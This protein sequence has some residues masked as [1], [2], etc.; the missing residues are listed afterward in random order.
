[1]RIAA[2]FLALFLAATPSFGQ[3]VVPGSAPPAALTG[4]IDFWFTRL[5]GATNQEDAAMAENEIQRLWLQSGSVTVD[6]VMR[7][8]LEATQAGVYG[9]ALDLLDGVIALQPGYAEAWHRRAIIYFEVED[10]AA[11]I[12]AAE[13]AIELEPRH[14]AAWAGLGQVLYRMGYLELAYQALNRALAIH[15]F[16]AGTRDLAAELEAQ[17]RVDI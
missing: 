6:L 17:L 16:L 11:C 3:A 5:T 14:F 13:K 1:M 7:W 15:P 10:Y 8:A 9:L 12:A 2:A 4:D